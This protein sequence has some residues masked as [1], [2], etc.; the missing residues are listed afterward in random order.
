MSYF[1]PAKVEC[2]YLYFDTYSH[3]ILKNENKFSTWHGIV[4]LLIF[5]L[6]YKKIITSGL[7]KRKERG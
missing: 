6:S 3:F 1:I 4:Y 2:T 7:L 5:I